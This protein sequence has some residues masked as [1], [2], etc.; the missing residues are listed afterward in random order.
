MHNCFLNFTDI[1]GITNPKQLKADYDHLRYI[2]QNDHCY[3]PYTY[4]DST[5]EGKSTDGAK[6][7]VKS[8]LKLT[9]PLQ[10]ATT[11]KTGR[12]AQSS[13]S[14]PS[15]GLDRDAS[16]ASN[17]SGDDVNSSVDNTAERSSEEEEEDEDTDYSNMSESDNDRD[18]DLD[19][20]VNDSHSRRAK[21][22]KKRKVQAKRLAHKK[23]RRST[24]DFTGSDDGLTPNRKKV[25]KISRK[26]LNTS[27]KSTTSNTTTPTVSTTVKTPATTIKTPV[28]TVKTPVTT[29]KTPTTAVKTPVTTVKTPTNTLTPR[30]TKITYVKESPQSQPQSQSLDKSSSTLP[31]QKVVCNTSTP[32]AT[33]S[34][35]NKPKSIIIVKA[36]EKKPNSSDNTLSGMSS[37]FV[38]DIIKKNPTDNI[39]VVKSQVSTPSIVKI[40]TS[41]PKPSVMTVHV[42]Q[43]PPKILNAVPK[44]MKTST[45]TFRKI[46]RPVI[47]LATEQDK[48]LDLIDSLVQEELSKSELE[49]PISSKNSQQ[50][51]IPAA[52]PNIVKMLETSETSTTIGTSELTQQHINTSASMPITYT[53]T[54]SVTDSQ[55]LPDDLLESFVNSDYLS[56]DLM[57]HVAKLVDED[58]NLQD[59]IDQ[60]VLCNNAASMA[61]STI[62]ASPPPPL[63]VAVSQQKQNIAQTTPSTSVKMADESQTVMNIAKQPTTITINPQTPGSRIVKRS[64]GRIITLPP[65]EAPTTRGAK[66]RAETTPTTDSQQKSKVITIIVQTESANAQKTLTN[67]PSITPV[68]S[69][70]GQLPKPIVA[71]ER[72]ASVAVKRS[73]IDFKPKRSMSISNP[74][75][76]IAGGEDDEDDEDKSDG[77]AN[78]ED[79]PHR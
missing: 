5:N 19:F 39:H 62:M 2:I 26:S 41:K 40:E 10:T 79:D 11:K 30:F 16:N 31:N 14:V 17:R 67:P 58:K 76:N 65:I 44:L 56:D 72:R 49:T 73:S 12:N 51:V 77:T 42:Q 22:V 15:N 23:R 59:I 69:S 7:D 24:V 34:N 46:T 27:S 52:I 29:V 48:Q 54:Q 36:K 75:P 38:P 32:L 53:T 35:E 43:N 66:R 20:N 61:P 3:T 21:K 63:P 25:A 1:A 70:P 33:T 64:D 8:K 78:S 50:T 4:A 74:Q 28:T 45:V 37:L 47:N 9:T 71:R 55:M 68:K 13:K 57:Q 18:S 6:C 60:Q